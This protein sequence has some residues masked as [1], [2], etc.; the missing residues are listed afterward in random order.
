M[1][2]WL[3]ASCSS[4][5]DAAAPLCGSVTPKAQWLGDQPASG[6]LPGGQ[7][8]QWQQPLC[9]AAAASDTAC[10]SPVCVS[11]AG[12]STAAVLT[13]ARTT[14]APS[15]TPSARLQS[16]LARRWT[17]RVGCRRSTT[18]TASLSRSYGRASTTPSMRCT[19]GVPST[20][21]AT[22]RRT[23]TAPSSTDAST[24]RHQDWSRTGSA[25]LTGG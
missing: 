13:G 12:A 25:S 7:H 11:P 2:G 18:P 17:P 5:M 14:G 23:S 8:A 3:A 6:L 24:A 1:S 22:A 4:G 15:R 16:A 9:T 21:T 20:R 10:V 19:P